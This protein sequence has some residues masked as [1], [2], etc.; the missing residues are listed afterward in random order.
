MHESLAIVETDDPLLMVE[1]L[2]DSKIRAG[3]AAQLSPTA[4]MV[5]SG[6]ADAFIQQLLKAGHT[7]KV[8]GR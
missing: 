8:H 4:A 2:A 1:L 3:V 7:P 5:T 6:G